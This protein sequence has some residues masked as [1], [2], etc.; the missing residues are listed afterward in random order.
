M[1][2]FDWENNIDFKSNYFNKGKTKKFKSNYF[3]KENNVY[4][5]VNN[6]NNENNLDF[7]PDYSNKD[8]NLDFKSDHFNKSIY[9][10][11]KSNYYN[12][13]NNRN[14]KSNYFNKDNNLDYKSNY[15][16]KRNNR[17]FKSNYYNNYNNLDSKSNYFNK[18]NNLDFKSNYYNKSNNRNFKSNYFNKDSNLDYK[19]N[20]YNKGNHRNFRSN[21]YNKR[22]NLDFKSNYYNK[23]NNRNFKSN[24]YNKYNNLDSKTNYYN[25]NSNRNFKSNYFNRDN[26]LDFK[27]NYYNKR[28]NRNFKSNHFKKGNNKN[29]KFNFSKIFLHRSNLLESIEWSLPKTARLSY[30]NPFLEI[31]N[32]K[33]L[34]RSPRFA[35]FYYKNT[36][37]IFKFLRENKNVKLESRTSFH[38][39]VINR[40]RSKLYRLQKRRVLR[41]KLFANYLKNKKRHNLTRISY[42][43]FKFLKKYTVYTRKGL[44]RQLI[45]S[46]RRKFFWGGLQRRKRI[47]F[48]INRRQLYS[49]KFK[50]IRNIYKKSLK[51]YLFFLNSKLFFK[52]TTRRNYRYGLN[53]SGIIVRKKINR[54]FFKKRSRQRRASI[55]L[56]QFAEK[57][58]AGI[59]DYN[60]QIY[61][62]ASWLNSL[63]FTKI[64]EDQD[65]LKILKKLNTIIT[66]KLFS[67][68]YLDFGSYCNTIL[69]LNILNTLHVYL[70]REIFEPNPG[71][72]KY[73][74][75]SKESTDFIKKLALK[76]RRKLNN[77]FSYNK[78]INYLRIYTN[79]LINKSN[80]LFKRSKKILFTVGDFSV[81]YINCLDSLKENIKF[82]K[83]NQ[84]G[85]KKIFSSH[86][87][88]LIILKKLRVLTKSLFRIIK[89]YKENDSNNK[90]IKSKFSNICK[91]IFKLIKRTDS[92]NIKIN[93]Q[94]KYLNKLY[95]ITL[96]RRKLIVRLFKYL[97][98]IKKK[99]KIKRKFLL[100]QLI[101][102][103]KKDKNVLSIFNNKRVLD[104]NFVKAEKLRRKTNEKLNLMLRR[105]NIKLIYFGLKKRLKSKRLKRVV[106]FKKLKRF[107]SLVN[108]GLL[109]LKKLKL[110]KTNK[111]LKKLKKTNKRVKNLNRVF[112][113]KKFSIFKKKKKKKSN[114]LQ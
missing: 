12:K 21:Y 101:K 107:L 22:N 50:I 104:Y 74:K 77:K 79:K 59:S 82:L 41:L 15:Y 33:P 60:D 45:R 13:R 92:L 3:T 90:E 30:Q 57:S 113:L 103:F 26:N 23:R 96:S 40:L 97:T 105:S 37:N 91:V 78:K 71:F 88:T 34:L 2:S 36:K 4:V 98:I 99:I 70:I 83:L 87:K 44:V 67:R 8:S 1:L 7:K 25:K 6:S 10:D 80:K 65:S 100:K 9:R 29:F 85:L 108:F 43:K 35:R 28:N 95:K 54:L 86:K 81:V 76:K 61:E 24:Y 52:N 39:H 109:S 46:L 64:F 75:I 17:N 14:F 42:T 53:L 31:T 58:I 32:Y 73:E 111:K 51:R 56:E 110:K 94:K 16:N 66:G 84:L 49:K 20:Y 102:N 19:S 47:F 11:F 89:A 27:S 62:I 106:K 112:R 63:N 38:N 55:A 48:F 93:K 5:R 68:K 72:S 69:R 18:D 114:L